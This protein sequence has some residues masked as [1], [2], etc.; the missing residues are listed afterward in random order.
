M[1]NWAFNTVEIVGNAED[2][3][4]IKEQL[5]KP[6]TKKSSKMVERDGVDGKKKWEFE[7]FM[8]TFS[9][10]T[11][12]LWNII[13]PTDIEAYEKNR[14]MSDSI[15]LS[16]PNW[17]EKTQAMQKTQKDWY[18]WNCTNWGTKWDCANSDDDEY[19]ETA[20]THESEGKLIYN[21][22]TAW[23]SPYEALKTLSTQYPD[24]EIYCESD[25]DDGCSHMLYTNGLE[26][27]MLRKKV[28][29]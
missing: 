4:K 22:Q 15:P 17:W 5:N 9:N 12:A 26:T 2:I 18:S 29:R 13:A 10:P 11:F 16:D 21:F 25:M 3:R 8:E 6:F 24:V 23:C 7:D 1:P 14:D 20:L 28:S 27:D 19:K